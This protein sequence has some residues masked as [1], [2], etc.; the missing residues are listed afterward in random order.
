MTVQEFKTKFPSF[1]EVADAKVKMQ[2]EESEIVL[3]SELFGKKYEIALGYHIAHELTLEATT[4]LN[5]VVSR[6]IERGSVTYA[7]FK[8]DQ[9]SIYYS[10]TSFG[11]KFLLLF[12]RYK[13][14]CTVYIAD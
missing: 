5:T 7:T 14:T 6:S 9:E 8:H 11:Q 12:N 1:L 3:N 2:I 13:P 4:N 10:S